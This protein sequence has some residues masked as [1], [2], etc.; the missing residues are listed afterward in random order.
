MFVDIVMP[1]GDIISKVFV[2]SSFTKKLF[3]YMLRNKPQH[4]AILFEK[5]NSI[6]TFLMRFPIDVIFLDK[7]FRVIKYI[8]K[9]EKG[10]AIWP[11]KNAVY[12]LESEADRFEK[13]EEGQVLHKKN[14]DSSQ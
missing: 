4:N 10:K 9:M 14:A 8:S 5:C 11:V 2:A 1:S 3:G 7:N 6:H 13:V 12:V